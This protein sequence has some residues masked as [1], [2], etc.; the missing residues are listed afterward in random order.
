MTG[1]RKGGRVHPFE[2][3]LTQ[4]GGDS[5]DHQ[6]LPG[7]PENVKVISQEEVGKAPT[8][9]HRRHDRKERLETL[10]HFLVNLPGGAGGIRPT[11][12]FI[13]QESLWEIVSD[14]CP[15]KKALWNLHH[16][17]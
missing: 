15:I 2:S 1:S 6:A 7:R 12:P 16:Q 11:Y 10:E 8:H 13:A 5:T 14:A 17:R 9:L 4:E 3:L